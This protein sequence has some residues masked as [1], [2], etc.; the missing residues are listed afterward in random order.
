MYVTNSILDRIADF[1]TGPFY[2]VQMFCLL[3]SYLG[4]ENFSVSYYLDSGRELPY[5]A[6]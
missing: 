6:V 2:W 1:D 5:E 4:I 3:V